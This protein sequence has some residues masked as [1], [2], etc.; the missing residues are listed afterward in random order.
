MIITLIIIALIGIYAIVV[1]NKA[2]SSKEAV[3]N[4]F[5]KIGV[6]LDARGKVIDS[7]VNLTNKYEIHEK[8]I[9]TRLAELRAA[10]QASTTINGK[11]EAEQ[12]IDKIVESGKL[13]IVF[14][15]YPELKFDNIIVKN[16]EA[17]QSEEQKLMYAKSAYN[18]SLEDYRVMLDKFPNNIILGIVGS[19]FKELLKEYEYWTI[20]AEERKVQEEKRMSF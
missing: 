5:K 10:S 6:Q 14:E 2:V 15:N 12:E 17:I 13:N 20:S 11:K 4:D 1:Y 8:G 19:K 16:Q 18:N 9:F 3:I 7:L